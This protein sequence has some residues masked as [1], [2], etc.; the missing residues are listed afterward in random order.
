VVFLDVSAETAARR[1]AADPGTGARP[2]LDRWSALLGRRRPHYRRAH[3]TVEVGA[4]SPPALA[5]RI[6]ELVARREPERLREGA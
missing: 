5:R 2:L 1:I 6:V 4:L 3:H